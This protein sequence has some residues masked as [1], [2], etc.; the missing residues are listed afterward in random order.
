MRTESQQGRGEKVCVN[1]KG[2]ERGREKQDLNCNEEEEK[3]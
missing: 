2:Q 3:S 1:P